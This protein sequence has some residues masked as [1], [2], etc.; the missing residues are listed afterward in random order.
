MYF[1]SIK[2]DDL[3][4]Y[5]DIFIHRQTDQWYLKS[6]YHM[7]LAQFGYGLIQWEKALLCDTFSH[8][9]PLVQIIAGAEQVTS[10][11]SAGELNVLYL[12]SFILENKKIS[13]IYLW[14][15]FY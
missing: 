15:H 10:I 2:Y 12:G 11:F 6:R 14:G 3:L 1:D 8:W 5:P 7:V 13:G 9:S 4:T